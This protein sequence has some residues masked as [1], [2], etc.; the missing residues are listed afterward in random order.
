MALMEWVNEKLRIQI[1]ENVQF[2][3]HKENPKKSSGENSMG[4]NLTLTGDSRIELFIRKCCLCK[5]VTLVGK[6]T[7]CA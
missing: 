5:Y 2:W 1:H 4:C 3:A 7:S 6:Y